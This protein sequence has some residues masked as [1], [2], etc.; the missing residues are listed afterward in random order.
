MSQ[1]N[2]PSGSNWSGVCVL[3]GSVPG[4]T[5]HFSRL[6]VV[7]QDETIRL[8]C[9]P[10]LGA[11]VETDSITALV[12]QHAEG[13]MEHVREYLDLDLHITNIHVLPMLTMLARERV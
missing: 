2:R 1:H 13:A 8:L 7:M 6:K 12:T 9:C 11:Q 10:M 4:L 3:V 5:V